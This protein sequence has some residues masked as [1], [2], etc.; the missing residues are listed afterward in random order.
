MDLD[1]LLVVIMVITVV[2]IVGRTVTNVVQKVIDYK[3]E[4]NAQVAG[5]SQENAPQVTER[6]RMIEDRLAVL[7]RIATDPEARRGADLAQEIEQLRIEQLQK[8]LS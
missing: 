5:T 1:F 4:Q 7:E 6:T 3:R 8:E 2:A